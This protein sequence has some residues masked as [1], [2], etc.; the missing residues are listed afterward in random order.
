LVLFDFAVGGGVVAAAAAAAAV[1]KDV[2]MRSILLLLGACVHAR[3]HARLLLV[4]VQ[5]VLLAYEMNGQ[6]LSR[7]HGFPLRVV[8]P[9]VVGARSVKWLSKCCAGAD[10]FA[11][12]GACRPAVA[13]TTAF[14]CMI[15]CGMFSCSF[16]GCG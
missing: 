6:P 5:D 12:D 10:V 1:G 2:G 4:C 13:E 11:K 16:T 8:V 3:T 15:Q 7:D 9:G 14:I